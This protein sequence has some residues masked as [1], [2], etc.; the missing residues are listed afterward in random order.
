MGGYLEQRAFSIFFKFNNMNLIN[1]EYIDLNDIG[2]HIN[3]RMTDEE[4]NQ[5]Y[6]KGEVR[7]VTEQARYPLSSIVTMLSSQD[8]SLNPEFQRRHRWNIQQKSRLIE[9]FIMNVPIPPIFLYEDSYSHYEVMDGLQRL[10][11]IYEFYSN[12]FALE[13]LEQWS[14]LNGKTYE[15]LPIQISRGIDRRYLSSII[16]LQETAKNDNDA[17]KL[18][19]LVFER[20]NSGGVQLKA[21]ESRNAV[22]GGVFNELCIRLSRN[23]YLCKTWGIPEPS[24]EEISLGVVD[25]Q[26][27]KNQ[28][29][30]EMEDVELVLRFFANRQR[31]T[32]F[33]SASN[34]R[35]FLDL[36]LKEAN[37]FEPV[38]ISALENLFKET[39]K[40]VYDL[41][42]ETA[43]WLFRSRSSGWSW[44]KRPTTAVYDSLMMA[45]SSYLDHKSAILENQPDIQIKLENFYRLNYGIFE[46][47]NVNPGIVKER[48]L[49]FKELFESLL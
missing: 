32:L 6:I 42:G 9:S 14:E 34:F 19:Q 11:A 44:Y 37:R 5:K 21:Q 15:A 47:R 3:V 22:F 27:L 28:S 10:T 33:R 20:I 38:T 1:G 23:I 40:F 7:I 41:M 25:D 26:L 31:D 35:N 29:F 36:Y 18:K 48:E 49:K 16:L 4:I 30:R 39:I 46:G 2:T 13:G 12:K 43:F 45:A 24:P 17:N 8:Y